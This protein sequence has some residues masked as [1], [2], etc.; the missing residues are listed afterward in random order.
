MVGG[1]APHGRPQVTHEETMDRRSPKKNRRL[2]R[3]N[4]FGIAGDWS[5]AAQNPDAWFSLG[6]EGG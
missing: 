5:T 6:C 2:D 1:A 4:V 3:V